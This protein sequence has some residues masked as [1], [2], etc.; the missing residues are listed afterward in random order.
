MERGGGQ[1]RRRRE[2]RDMARDG[3]VAARSPQMFAR[4]LQID[5]YR[6][7]Y[8][9]LSN[10]SGRE[11]RRRAESRRERERN[12]FAFSQTSADNDVRSSE[13]ERRL[14]LLL[15]LISRRIGAIEPYSFAYGC[16]LQGREYGIVVYIQAVMY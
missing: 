2:A 3:D 12:R 13:T 1:R 16:K 6:A 4:S 8:S 10:S 14:R 11:G 15:W 5:I 9:V 7:P